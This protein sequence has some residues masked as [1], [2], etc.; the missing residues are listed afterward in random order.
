[1][2]RAMIS[3]GAVV[4]MLCMATFASA[5]ERG[6][7]KEQYSGKV[8]TTSSGLKYIDLVVGDG[9]KAEQGDTA[10]VHYTGWLQDGGIP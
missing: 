2:T 7:T 3:I 5:G 8:V 4:A 6:Q 10:I 1:M 9:R